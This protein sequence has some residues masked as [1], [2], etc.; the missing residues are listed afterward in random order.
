MHIFRKSLE[1]QKKKSKEDEKTSFAMTSKDCYEQLSP[2]TFKKIIS[3]N[4]CALITTFG[5]IV[6]LHKKNMNVITAITFLH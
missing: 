5:I 6:E 1:I 3:N 4:Q 2:I